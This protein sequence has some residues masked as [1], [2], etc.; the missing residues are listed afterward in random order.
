[1]DRD[2]GCGTQIDEFEFRSSLIV[3]P[4][5][6]KLQEVIDCGNFKEDLLVALPPPDL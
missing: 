5:F 2:S 6:L 1:M 4:Q 3:C